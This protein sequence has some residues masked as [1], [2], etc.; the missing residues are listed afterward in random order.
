MGH[1]LLCEPLIYV[2]F[3]EH[4]ELDKVRICNVIKD[5]VAQDFKFFI[6]PIC[7]ELFHEAAVGK[8]LNEE[9]LVLEFVFQGLLDGCQQFVK[10]LNVALWDLVFLYSGHYSRK[11]L[12]WR[13]WID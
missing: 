5:S 3:L 4:G 7:L 2:I 12:D 6:A 9:L 8:R 10:F 13:F 1:V 11:T